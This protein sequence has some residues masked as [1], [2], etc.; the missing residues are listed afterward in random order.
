MLTPIADCGL[1]GIIFYSS[2]VSFWDGLSVLNVR[3]VEFLVAL[4]FNTI[5]EYVLVMLS[6]KTLG[7]F[8]TY[9]MS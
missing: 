9:R 8:I 5:Q 2:L 4:S 6:G 1:I 3:Y 7:G